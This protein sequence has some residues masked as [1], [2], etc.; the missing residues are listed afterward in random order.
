M[1]H[2][3]NASSYVSI[4]GLVTCVLFQFKGYV[5][6]GFKVPSIWAM[7]GSANCGD[8]DKYM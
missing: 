3:C 2:N 4:P 6:W 8:E 7:A 5:Q 1:I